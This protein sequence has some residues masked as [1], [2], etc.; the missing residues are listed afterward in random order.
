MDPKHAILDDRPVLIGRQ[1]AWWEIK[2]KWEKAPFVEVFCNAKLLDRRTFA[3]IWPELP[4]LPK[5][6]FQTR[7]P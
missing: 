3:S 6:A 7:D 2:G 1:E 4:P 5:M